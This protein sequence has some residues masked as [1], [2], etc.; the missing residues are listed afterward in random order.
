MIELDYRNSLAQEI[1]SEGIS[2]E[3]LAS[4]KKEAAGVLGKIKKAP[5]G[6]MKLPLRFDAARQIKKDAENY[7]G[8]KNLVVLGIGGSALGNITLKNMLCH[9]YHNEGKNNG[10]PNLYVMDNVDPVW[11]MELSE[12]IR[13]EDTVFNI[14]TKSGSTAETLSNFFFFLEKLKKKTSDWK[15]HLVITTGSSGFLND[16][17]LE[18]GIKKYPVPEDVGGRYSVL[19]EVGLFPAAVTGIDIESL[20]E[21]AADAEENEHVPVA[22][23]ALQ[24]YFY[25]KGKNI[26]VFMPYSKKLESAA[27]WFRQLWAESLGKNEKTGPTPVK[28][29]GTTDQH[30]Q[31][32]LYMEG[33]KDKAYTFLSV[34]E[35]S[36]ELKLNY[37]GHFLGE[38]TMRDLFNAELEGTMQALAGAGRPV[39]NFEIPRIDAY[40][41]GELLYQLET[42]CVITGNML[43]IDPFNQPG[44]ETGK[45]LAYKILGK[46]E[47]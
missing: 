13:M 26:T 31:V 36:P 45:K 1:G 2:E 21:G 39:M 32:Q 40:N 46:K 22:Y 14:I 27:D 11:T 24:Y 4:L 37:D 5:P 10:Y 16:F 9:S 30:S 17:A 18:H 8:F 6:F 7:K 47:V 43:G 33:P 34:K 12:T 35:S 25:K 3:K 19:S 44:V 23:A 42:A 29:L 41:A 38:K 20:L 28:A 15:E